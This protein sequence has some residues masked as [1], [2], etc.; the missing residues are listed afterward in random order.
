VLKD[1]GLQRG[2]L[3]CLD[4]KTGKHLWESKLPKAAQVYYS[5]PVLAGDRLFCVR[6]DGMVIS[7]RI[8]DSGLAEVKTHP[9]EEGVIASPICLNGRLILRGDTHLFCFGAE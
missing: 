8:G 1:S 7:G 5:S 3:T 4:A 6:E 2:R 9:L